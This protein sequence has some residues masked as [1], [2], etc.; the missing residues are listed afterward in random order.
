MGMII[1]HILGAGGAV[2]TPSHTPAAYWVTVDGAPILMDPGPGALVRLVKSGRRPARG[3]RDRPGPA[4]P[5]APRPHRRPGG[6][7]LR[8]ALA[9]ADLAPS[10]WT[11]SGPVGLNELLDQLRGIYGT[12]AGAPAAGT[13]GHR[14]RPRHQCWTIPAADAS[15]SFAVDHPQDRL[16]EGALGYRFFGCRRQTGWFFPGTPG[17]VRG[18]RCGPGADLL[19][20]E[21]STTGRT[22]H[23][24]D[25]WP[26]E[27]W[28]SFAPSARPELVVLTHQ[29]PDAAE[30]RPGQG[31]G[32]IL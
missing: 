3:R 2:P 27:M 28:A 21:C 17:P 18:W 10:R 26:P 25:T 12:L 13:G 31:R 23:R 22:G 6:P 29:Y 24:Q 4:D 16:A 19:V 11:S 30:D 5:S 7:A 20:V 32:R 14:D 8:A 15:S 1:F 9:G